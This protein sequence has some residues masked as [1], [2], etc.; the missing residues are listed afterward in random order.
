L[1]LP[2]ASTTCG[3]VCTDPL[4]SRLT[5][6][7]PSNSPQA[8][9][10]ADACHDNE[11]QNDLSDRPTTQRPLT[12]R[13]RVIHRLCSPVGGRPASPRKSQTKSQR[14]PTSGDTQRRQATVTPGQVP[15]ERHRATSSDAR[16]VTGGQGVAGSNPA[17]PT[18]SRVFSN[19]TTPHQSQQK[20][21]SP[22]KR[23][24]KRRAPIMS[25]SALPGHS[26]NRQSQGSWP[27]KGSNI[28]EPPRICTATPATANRRDTIPSAPA[29]RRL[30]AHG[31]QQLPT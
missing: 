3:P 20:S 10:Q 28:A 11:P 25:P 17:V 26:P 9:G 13:P 29:R 24:S 18:G 5:G 6:R 12:A 7:Q 30:D 2:S 16:N 1:S 23:P 4:L 14:R 15:T 19:I 22:P 8:P 27:V 31:L 21:H